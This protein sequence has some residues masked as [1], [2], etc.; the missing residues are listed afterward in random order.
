MAIYS[1]NQGTSTRSDLLP[2]VASNRTLVT[3]D[4]T[5]RSRF[6]G[7]MAAAVSKPKGEFLGRKLEATGRVL[8]FLPRHGQNA[9]YAN[10]VRDAAGDHKQID[11]TYDIASFL[12][13]NFDDYA[14]IIVDELSLATRAAQQVSPATED[15]QLPNALLTA[16]N[17]LVVSPISE[18]RVGS[19]SSSSIGETCILS[20]VF[21]EVALDMDFIIV[22][23]RQTGVEQKLNTDG[24]VWTPPKP[25]EQTRGDWV[26]QAAMADGRVW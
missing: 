8:I 23:D 7:M 5:V 15:V 14:L 2:G 16:K 19:I 6:A 10:I 22:K 17:L 25:V 26:T 12:G 13:A 9:E 1:L 11:W 21:T 3:G 18:P 20:D 4:P 24:S